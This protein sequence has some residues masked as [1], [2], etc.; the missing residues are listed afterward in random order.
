[1]DNPLSAG[2]PKLPL[3]V[4]QFCQSQV[5]LSHA[6][7]LAQTGWPPGRES[8]APPKT[9][10]CNM[11]GC[12]DIPPAKWD[13][14]VQRFDETDVQI[15]YGTWFSLAPGSSIESDWKLRSE[16]Q[17][18]LINLQNTI[19]YQVRKSIPART[20]ET[21][22]TVESRNDTASGD[23]YTY[24]ARLRTD[25]RSCTTVP[26]FPNVWESCSVVNDV[27]RLF[28]TINV[29]VR[30]YIDG[31]NL[32]ARVDSEFVKGDVPANM[33]ALFKLEEVFN[34]ATGQIFRSGNQ[35]MYNEAMQTAIQKSVEQSGEK[36]SRKINVPGAQAFKYRTESATTEMTSKGAI[37][38]F[39]MSASIPSAV[40]CDVRQALQDM[41]NFRCVA[42]R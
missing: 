27:G 34:F 28:N 11:N 3:G 23:T 9:L 1:M 5:N 24:S 20:C 38:K 8:I 37:L 41:N 25:V 26:C 42:G 7:C 12:R 14:L 17:L 33:K 32:K 36:L 30:V 40:V 18:L 19:D 22:T 2:P 39:R 10:A 6:E 21:D 29:R 15:Q 4:I 13:I 35:R 16:T 31:D